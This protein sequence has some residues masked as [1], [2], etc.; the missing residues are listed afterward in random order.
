MKH[1]VWRA[2]AGAALLF[3][4]G[5]LTGGSAVRYFAARRARIAAQSGAPAVRQAVMLW[6]LDA[7]LGL[8]REQRR[9]LEP[10]VRAQGDAYRRALESCAPELRGL[11]LRLEEEAAPFLRPDQRETLHRLFAHYE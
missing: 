8:D 10:I 6:A 9:A 2:I 1:Y 5:G 11:R 4:L 3:V 7:N